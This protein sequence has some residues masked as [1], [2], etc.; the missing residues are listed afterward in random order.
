VAKK[1]KKNKGTR[2]QIQ[3]KNVEAKKVQKVSHEYLTHDKK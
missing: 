2:L 3:I 1:W